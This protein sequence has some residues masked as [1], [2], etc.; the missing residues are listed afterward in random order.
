[1]GAL[2]FNDMVDAVRAKVADPQNII[3]D[4]IELAV[5]EAVDI[6]GQYRPVEKVVDT[7]GDGGFLYSLPADYSEGFSAVIFIAYPFDNT[8]AEQ[9]ILSPGVDYEIIRD[10]TSLKL[11]F[12]TVVPAATETYRMAYTALHSI[13]NT[14]SPPNS[15]PTSD[16]RAVVNL[17]AALLCEM[18]AADFEK[19]SKSTLPDITLD[20]R[21]KA[22]EYQIQADRYYRLFNRHLGI[23]EDGKPEAASLHIDTDWT[24]STGERPLVHY[25]Q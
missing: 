14:G 3:E 2:K 7:N 19:R 20:L 16:E 24:M 11:R 12:L 9:P 25:R 4:A 5:L 13:A 15:I 21:G 17:G 23:P 1:M 6:Y 10:T 18:L 22:N 8:Q